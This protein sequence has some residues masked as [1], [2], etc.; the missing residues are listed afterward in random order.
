M[1]VESTVLYGGV[2]V[3]LYSEVIICEN[4]RF[5]QTKAKVITTGNVLKSA[6]ILCHCPLSLTPAVNSR[7]FPK[8]NPTSYINQT[9][10]M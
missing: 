7:H 10:K 4:T 9:K 8:I 1:N 3:D 5:I 2:P 6:L